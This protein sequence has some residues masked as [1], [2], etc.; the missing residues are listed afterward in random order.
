MF[1]RSFAIAFLASSVSLTALGAA[2]AVEAQDVANRFKEL[3][4]RQGTTAS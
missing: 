1:S 2:Q 3:M 4:A